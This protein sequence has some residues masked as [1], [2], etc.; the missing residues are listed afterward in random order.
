MADEGLEV[1]TGEAG[2]AEDGA[3][4]AELLKST[5]AAELLAGMAALVVATVVALAMAVVAVVAG[6]MATCGPR[7]SMAEEGGQATWRKRLRHPP[8]VRLSSS[9]RCP[10][11]NACSVQSFAQGQNIPR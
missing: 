9:R 5:A 3:V 7:V 10:T 11:L 6:G 4:A 8:C 2:E 1:E